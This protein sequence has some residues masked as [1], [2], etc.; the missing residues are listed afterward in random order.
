M[1]AEVDDGVDAAKVA[2]VGVSVGI[3]EVGDLHSFDRVPVPV[4]RPDVEQRQVVALTQRRQHLAR[5]EPGR[6]RDQN[7]SSCHP[8]EGGAYPAGEARPSRSHPSLI[9]A[10]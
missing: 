1:N 4:R 6:A 8:Y 7:V 2:A 5:D 10:P 3:H 9:T